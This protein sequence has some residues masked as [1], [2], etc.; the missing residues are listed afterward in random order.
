MSIGLG[1]EVGVWMCMRMEM[2]FGMG[3]R[4]ALSLLVSTGFRNDI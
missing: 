3:M 2:R 4:T 1:T